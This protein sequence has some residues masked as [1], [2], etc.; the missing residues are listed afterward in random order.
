MAPRTLLPL[1]VA[2]LGVAAVLAGVGPAASQT[3][4]APE[5]R[6][7]TA[8]ATAYARADRK[9]RH[10]QV[11][12]RGN[13]RR[14][15]RGVVVTASTAGGKGRASASVSVRHVNLFDGLVR[16]SGVRV[17]ARAGAG[18]SRRGRIGGLRIAGKKRGSPAR[19][20]VY[21]LDG[22]GKLTVLAAGRKGIVG[23]R[24][25]LTRAYEGTRKGTTVV[26][27]FAAAS[28]RDAVRAPKDRKKGGDAKEPPRR[29]AP[30]TPA[31]KLRAI[32]TKG[33]FIFPVAQG[34]HRYK[35][36]WGAPRQN[37][38]AHQGND[39]F[40]PAGTP[41]LAVTDGVLRRVGTAR[42][43][44]NRLYLWS[45]RGDY[46]FYGHLSSFESDARSGARVKA[47]QVL[48]F[49]GSTG[50]AEPTPPHVHF[51]IHPGGGGPVNP[52]PFLRAWEK[53]RDVPTAAWVSRYAGA[54]PGT[55][56]VVRD[57]LA[58]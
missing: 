21:D 18:G 15:A 30:R 1:P 31:S 4:D 7:A 33:G 14:T 52:Y 41:V 3:G 34:R 22:H 43:P 10:S 51:E 50:D 46:Y 47:G 56:V 9:G 19:R 8:S 28:A 27:A 48:G 11:S 32:S 5:A 16:A 54:R 42:V 6:P 49:V 26:V 29:K 36:D 24:A 44:G 25:R 39:I 12:V 20:R 45:D 57:Y 38:G 13:G 17:S 55:L 23:M 37:T 40:A 2:G 35:N 58:E 53:K